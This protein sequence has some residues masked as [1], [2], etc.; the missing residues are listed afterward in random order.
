MSLLLTLTIKAVITSDIQFLNPKQHTA[1]H[2]QM[3]LFLLDGMAEHQTVIASW[4][5]V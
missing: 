1:L 3:L 4:P 2:E 5:Y